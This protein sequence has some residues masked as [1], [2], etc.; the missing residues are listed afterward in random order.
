MNKVTYFDVEYANSRNKSICQIGVVCEDYKTGEPYFPER[1][2]YVNPEDGFDPICVKIHGITKEKVSTA[3]IFPQV[4]SEISDYFIN[5]VIIGHNVR[6]ADLD[7]LIKALV[8]YN[9]EVPELYYIDTLELAKTF[10]P[11]CYINDY[12]ISS[13][14]DFYGIDHDCQHDAFDDACVCKDVLQALVR[15][16]GFDIDKFVHRYDAHLNNVFSLYVS[17]PILRKSVSDLYGIIKGITIDK[18]INQKELDFIDTWLKENKELQ[19][20][21]EFHS[22]VLVV[23]DV[24]KDSIITKDEANAIDVSVKKF[25]EN[26]RTSPETLATQMLNGIIKGISADGVITTEEAVQ[27]EKWLYDNAFLNGHFPYDKLLRIVEAILEDGIVT[28]I[29]SRELIEEINEILDPVATLSN[30]I[31]D[32]SGRSVCLSGCFKFGEKSE[33]A[34][35]IEQ[36][37]GKIDSSVKK[38][39]DIL[40]VGAN[41]CEAFSNGKYGSKVKKAMEFNQ[42]GCSILIAKEDD[43]C[44]N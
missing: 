24:L 1:S 41:E 5:S 6:N 23:E 28:E 4:W 18:K 21:P 35:F 31:I 14:C 17:N 36:K 3:P 38:T 30:H 2:I 10:I 12:S 25:F 7:A 19:N 8:R 32:F 22:F 40:I 26:V 37:G 33:V 42:K 15:S 16:E 44:W 34:K 39:T 27:F 20:V 13:L 29:E 9:L 43:C 11:S